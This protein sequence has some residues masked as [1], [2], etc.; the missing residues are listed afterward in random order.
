LV[1]GKPTTDPFVNILLDKENYNLTDNIVTNFISVNDHNDL[2][3]S[4]TG[5]LGSAWGSRIMTEEGFILNNAMNF[6]TYGQSNANENNNVEAGK[7]PRGLFTPLL[8]YNEKNPCVHRFSVSYS[9][10]GTNDDFGLTELTG[11]MVKLFTDYSLYDKSLSE[12]RV[13]YNFDKNA[14]FENGFDS[15]V[16]ADILD[17]K[18]FQERT[19]CSFYGID[20][21]MKKDHIIYSKT[22]TERSMDSAVTFNK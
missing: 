9:H 12:K 11:I 21:V 5:T 8:A 10:H 1:N 6:F 22:D 3:I 18:L 19:N 7:Q 4:Y 13:Q 16:K 20:L 2:M 14:C 17:K 15:K